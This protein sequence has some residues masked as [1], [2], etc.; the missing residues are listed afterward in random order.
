MWNEIVCRLCDHT[1]RLAIVTGAGG[2]LKAV[3][4]TCKRCQK[5]LARFEKTEA[6]QQFLPPIAPWYAANNRDLR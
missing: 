2:V 4:V 3:T 1:V 5:V 6:E